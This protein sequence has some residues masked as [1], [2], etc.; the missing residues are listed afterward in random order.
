[1]IY[2]RQELAESSADHKRRS[3][4]AKRGWR[5]RRSA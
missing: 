4:A 2:F 1:M 3:K 5:T